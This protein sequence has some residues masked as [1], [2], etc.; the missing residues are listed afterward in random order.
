M[1]LDDKLKNKEIIVLDG[2]VGTEIARFG[3]AMHD[4]A[5][6]AVATK[7]QPEIVRQVHE[8]Y[9]HAGAD[10]ITTNTFATC[11]HVLE[12]AN[13][14]DETVSIITRS[15]EL[16]REAITNV[17]PSRPI[18][19]AGSMANTI[20]YIPG[21]YKPDP[22]Y[23][24]T[25]E[26]EESDYREMAQTLAKAGV[27]FILMEMMTDIERASRATKAA[28]NT[29]LPVWVGISCSL[30]DDGAVVARNVQADDPS[31]Q[32]DKSLLRKPMPLEPIIDAMI[33]LNPQVVGIMHSSIEA[34]QAGLDILLKRW[35]GPVMIYPE[36]GPP[37]FSGP[38]VFA[39]QCRR[40]VEEGVQII[41]G[42][43]DTTVEHIRT[44]VNDLPDAVG[45][46]STSPQETAPRPAIPEPIGL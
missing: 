3:G 26:E 9:I 11:R 28:L 13:L 41:G 14:A 7:T 32:V 25:A 6:C 20:A 40:W 34:T 2:G 30:S 42:C 19:I 23:A 44:M 27:D 10:V 12:A 1:I 43:C 8:A 35:N 45:E 21:T 24:P 39:A 17:A 5:W 37:H 4:A 36:T 33:A 46:R 38:D 15:V 29:G 31:G 16:A 22:E 18:A